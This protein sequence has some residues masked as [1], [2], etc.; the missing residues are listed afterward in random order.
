MDDL[1]QPLTPADCDLRGLPYMPLDVIRLLDSDMFA[2]ATGDEFKAT[3]ALWCKSWT[4]IPAASLP[5]KDA[6]LA[7]LSGA[8]NW[9]RVKKGAMRGWI[10]CSDERWYHPVVAEKALAALPAREEFNSKKSAD[11]ERK[12]R[13]RDDRKALFEQLKSHGVV[14]DWNVSTKILRGMASQYL[15]Q[16]QDDIFRDSS[17][18]MSQHVTVSKGEGEGEGEERERKELTS[19]AEDSGGIAVPDREDPPEAYRPTS[20]PLPTRVEPPP[21]NNP[22]IAMAVALRLLGVNAAFTHPAVQDWAERE[23]SMEIL[24]AAV[25][26]ARE[27][28]G[29]TAAI[30]PNYLVGI[31]AELLDPPP[32][33]EAKAPRAAGD[34]W[35]WKKSDA[36][37]DKKGRELGLFARSGESYRDYAHRIEDAIAKRKGPTP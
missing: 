14:P 36:G 8:K 29:P 21:S 18:D 35:A 30:P 6:V 31:V 12:A 11:A 2:E 23:V 13:E 16:N 1:P 32:M 24:T 22:A 37:I 17:R 10:L 9:N 20:A 7:H 5:N 33:A 4:Q 28:K 27:S 15:S 3:V 34:D 25:A 19:K 26:K